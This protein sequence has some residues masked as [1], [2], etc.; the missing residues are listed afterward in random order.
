MRY[1][2]VYQLGSGVC[3]LSTQYIDPHFALVTAQLQSSDYVL[4]D[5]RAE[6]SRKSKGLKYRTG[7]NK[8]AFCEHIFF[9][10]AGKRDRLS[11]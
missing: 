5:E 1:I 3:Q 11:Y 10:S 2:A 8:S 9:S 4:F 6:Q 7:E